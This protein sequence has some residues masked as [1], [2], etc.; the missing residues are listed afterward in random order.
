MATIPLVSPTP[1]RAALLSQESSVPPPYLRVFLS[2]DNRPSLEVVPLSLQDSISLTE[3]RSFWCDL[4]PVLLRNERI[5]TYVRWGS[6]F[7]LAAYIAFPLWLA[8]LSEAWHE[9]LL[10]SSIVL[11]MWGFYVARACVQG[12]QLRALQDAC[13][14]AENAVFRSHGW[15]LDAHHEMSNV[16]CCD[17]GNRSVVYFIP[18]QRIGSN[19][20]ASGGAT[21]EDMDSLASEGYLRI[22]LFKND[23]FVCQWSPIALS[24]LDSFSTLPNRLR[25]LEEQVWTSF[26]SKMMQQSKNHLMVHRGALVLMWSLVVVFVSLQ[27]FFIVGVLSGDEFAFANWLGFVAFLMIGMCWTSRFGQKLDL[28]HSHTLELS[29]QGLYIEC[30]KVP[31]CKSYGGRTYYLYLYPGNGERCEPN[32]SA[33]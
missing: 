5:E 23:A 20:S 30:R 27:Y 2:R 19:L 12:V 32:R 7:Y 6:L 28:V 13:R 17:I 3:W 11:L 22:E 8:S 26:W 31:A 33:C 4:E 18:L 24:Y 10:L 29:R 21:A 16:C 14:S 25:P 9:V 15:A 1:S